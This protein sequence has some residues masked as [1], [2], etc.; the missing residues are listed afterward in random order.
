MLESA[1]KIIGLTD[2]P[3]FA[4]RHPNGL[5]GLDNLSIVEVSEGKKGFWQADTFPRNLDK[6]NQDTDRWMNHA[7]MM[8][9]ANEALM[10]E[11]PNSGTPFKLYEAQQIEGKSLHRWRQGQIASFLDE[12][13]DDWVLKHIQAEI[14]ND[15][16]FLMELSAD[17]MME[18]AEKGSENQKNKYLI[19]KVLNGQA[20]KPGEAEEQKAK[21]LEAF[22]KGGNKK[23]INILK[24]DFKK[25]PTAVKTNIKSKQKELA[26]I[27]DKMVSFV[28]QVLQT[29]Q[30][31]QDPEMIKWTNSILESS[32]LSPI[33]FSAMPQMQEATG[34]STEALQ[35]VSKQNEGNI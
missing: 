8:G 7:Q 34:K 10:G 2:D 27:T 16:S 6:F 5:K 9:G 29:P 17:E 3:K 30:I 4:Q 12:I 33:M 32:G 24:E 20:I 35:G 31:R 19:E 11:E 18:I 25:T 26:L 1:S 21:V 22:T 28:R 13:Y 23:F 14:T 15:Q